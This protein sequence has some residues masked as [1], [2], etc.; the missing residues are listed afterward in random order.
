MGGLFTGISMSQGARLTPQLAFLNIGGLYLY[1]IAQCPM[2]AVHGRS[3]AIHNAMS[4]AL[5]GYVG[6]SSGNLGIPFV[7]AYFFYR[8]P[9]L[10]APV[11]GGVVY[12]GIAFVLSAIL[13][14]KPI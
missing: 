1:H 11:V 7:D 12:G 10:P 4:G 6:V 8:N 5:L 13:G 14:G 3:S 9:Q 2:E